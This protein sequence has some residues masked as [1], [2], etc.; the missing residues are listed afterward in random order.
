MCPIQQEAKV[1]FLQ[2]IHI[3]HLTNHAQ[4]ALSRIFC[5]A[6]H[7]AAEMCGTVADHSSVVVLVVT[8]S[9]V[10]CQYDIMKAY[11]SV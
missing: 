10:L 11:D 8:H 3:M 4:M 6:S 5:L 2:W 1:H 9:C 7:I